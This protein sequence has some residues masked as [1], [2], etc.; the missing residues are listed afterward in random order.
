MSPPPLLTEL[1]L[2]CHILSAPPPKA[3]F[4]ILTDRPLGGTEHPASSCCGFLGKYKF[5]SVEL[6]EFS[7]PKVG[8]HS[9]AAAGKSFCV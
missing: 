7:H 6:L 5:L 8:I 9:G 3:S 4:H 1:P 2:E